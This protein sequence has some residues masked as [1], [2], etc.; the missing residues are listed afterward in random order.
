MPDRG[1]VS[2]TLL[3]PVGQE[4]GFAPGLV[5]TLQRRDLFVLQSEGLCCMENLFLDVICTHHPELDLKS[6]PFIE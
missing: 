4:P 3:S 5:W 6:Q 2:F 1:V